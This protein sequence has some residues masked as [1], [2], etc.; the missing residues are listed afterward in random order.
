M[1]T[2]STPCRPISATDARCRQRAGRRRRCAGRPCRRWRAGAAAP[3]AAGASGA[4]ESVGQLAVRV[5]GRPRA[6]TRSASRSRRHTCSSMTDSSHGARLDVGHQGLAP[7]PVRAGHDEVETTERGRRRG[8]GGEPVA[9]EQAVP[10]PLALD[11]LVVD[12]DLLGG[13]DAVDVVVGGHDRPRLRLLDRDLERQQ[14]DLAQRVLGDDRVHVVAQGLGLVGDEVLEAGADSLAL[15]ALDVC[16]GEPAG[17]QRVLG[18]GLEEPAA[19]RRAVQVDGRA[20][21]RRGSAG[22]RPPRRASRRPRGRCPRSRRSRAGWRSGRGRRAS[23]PV[24]L[25]RARRW[26]RRR[27]PSGPGR[28]RPRRGG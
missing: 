7:R 26:G 9:H 15:Q 23:P 8:L 27:R 24:N 20:R 11:H 16:R 2:V 5:A 25:V 1:Q 10:A 13:G 6:P 4:S 14:V 22:A 28:S 21:G 12:V 3:G 18:V 17:E 19:E